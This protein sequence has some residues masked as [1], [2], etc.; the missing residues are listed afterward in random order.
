MQIHIYIIL[1]A[2]N[3]Q[4]ERSLSWPQPTKLY[5]NKVRKMLML[6]I[7]EYTT[8]YKIVVICRLRLM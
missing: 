5:T 1:I 8:R 2:F 7:F 3:Y 4:T 6:G